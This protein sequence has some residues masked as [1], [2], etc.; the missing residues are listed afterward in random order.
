LQESKETYGENIDDDIRISIIGLE[1]QLLIEMGRYSN[2]QQLVREAYDFMHAYGNSKGGT[3]KEHRKQ[4][5][6]FAG[7]VILAARASLERGNIDQADSLL[8]QHERAF[9]KQLGKNT[10]EKVDY[11]TLRARIYENSNNAK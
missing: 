9:K 2:A 3:K 10:W 11:T 6:K 7:F 8:R 5:Q 4:Y 1:A